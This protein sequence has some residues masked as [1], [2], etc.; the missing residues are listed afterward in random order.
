MPGQFVLLSAL[1]L[2]ISAPVVYTIEAM[3]PPADMSKY[4]IKKNCVITDG[5]MVKSCL[6]DTESGFALGTQ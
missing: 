2:G 1:T 6:V 5:V 4:E 3:H